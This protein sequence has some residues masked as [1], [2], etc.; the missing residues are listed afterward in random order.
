MA[1]GEKAKTSVHHPTSPP[2]TVLSSSARLAPEIT[3]K[4]SEPQAVS[5]E[6]AL[7][8]YHTDVLFCDTSGETG[9][10]DHCMEALT[11]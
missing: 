2:H 11:N 3:W 10:C 5:T 9:L 8:V 1:K 4:R 7:Q 6:R